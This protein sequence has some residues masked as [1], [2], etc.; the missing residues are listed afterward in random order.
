MA[1]IGFVGLGNMGLPMAENLLKAGHRL[2]VHD[3]A[4]APRAKLA[5][6][7]AVAVETAR[8]VAAGAEAIVTMLPAGAQVEAV[9]AGPDGL[10]A[11]AAPGTLLIDCSTI[12][13]ATARRVAGA[14]A[15]RGLAM[16]DAPVSGGIAGAAAATL[17]FMV[18]GE[19]A[20]FEAARPLLQ[21]MGKAV[22]HAG[23][24]GAGQAAKICNNLILGISMIGVCEAFTLAEALGLEAQKLFDIA[25]KSSGQCWSLTSY[26]PVPGPVPT[27][28]ANRD[29]RPGFAAAMML[30]DLRLAADAAAASGLD[31]PLGTA[32]ER[33]Y[34]AF[35]DA[36]QEG[37]DFS[38]IIRLIRDTRESGDGAAR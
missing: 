28:P 10:I 12:D 36:G 6:A 21:A 32:A 24:A 3:I 2:R 4:A 37:V 18:G 29:Y 25:G 33:L 27:S 9:H 23:P 15:A 30:K 7:G 20:A 19:A 35:A 5:A 16:L 8:E 38:G 34:A 22:I 11:A 31:L 14:A 17:T 1:S 26:C 13:V